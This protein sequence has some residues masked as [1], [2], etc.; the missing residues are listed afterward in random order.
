M[1]LDDIWRLFDSYNRVARLYP[2]VLTLAPLL[3]TLAALFPSLLVANIPSGIFTAFGTACLLYLFASIARSRGKSV[4]E[5]LLRDWGGW[6]TTTLLRHRDPTLDRFTTARYHARLQALCPNLRFP[7]P[8][9]EAQWPAEA[10]AIYRSATKRLIEMRRGPEFRM[11]HAENASYGFRR[12]MLG[13]KP[14]A[15]L[16]AIVAASI[17]GVIWWHGLPAHSE[18]SEA[19]RAY[20]EQRW[21]LYALAALDLAYVILWLV[22]IRPNFVAQAGRE[23]AE[24]LFRTLEQNS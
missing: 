17:A 12:N 20:L 2:A 21:Y 18:T 23:Y 8:E 6:P 5:R 22:M 19:V 7:S 14:M 9:E 4:E 13:L 24:A 11:L 16:I 10:D 15:V 3:W 1:K